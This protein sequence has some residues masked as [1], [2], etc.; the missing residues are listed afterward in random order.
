MSNVFK[1]ALPGY[2]A[3]TDTNL[4]HFALYVDG[5]T[6]HIL[7]KEKTRG[8]VAVNNGSTVE[9]NHNLT[10]V[11]FALAYATIGG[12]RIFLSLM[13]SVGIN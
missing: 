11:P 9:I 12:N 7:I 8:S 2:N 4:D 10:Y 1:V 13:I 3:E 6:D 5:T